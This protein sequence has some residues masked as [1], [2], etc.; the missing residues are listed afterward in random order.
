MAR[1]EQLIVRQG[2]GHPSDIDV[3]VDMRFGD[4]ERKLGSEFALHLWCVDRDR[5]VG[6]IAPIYPNYPQAYLTRESDDVIEQKIFTLGR[7]GGP[8][9][10]VRYTFRLQ[11]SNRAKPAVSRALSDDKDLILEI[12]VYAALVPETSHASNS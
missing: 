12:K 1:I 11:A 4:V 3:E 2:A 7:P 6:E 9:Q 5:H 8:T 10:S